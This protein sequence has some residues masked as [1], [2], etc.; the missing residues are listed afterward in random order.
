MNSWY[1]VSDNS[2]GLLKY[3]A[4]GYFYMLAIPFILPCY[5]NMYIL[6]H[7]HV[8]KKHCSFLVATHVDTNVKRYN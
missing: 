3:L 7:K 2:G 5:S 4:I 6:S 1:D 8:M